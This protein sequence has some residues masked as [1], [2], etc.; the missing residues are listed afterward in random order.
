MTLRLVFP[1][2]LFHAVEFSLQWPQCIYI[3]TLVIVSPIDC[4]GFSVGW[5][6]ICPCFAYSGFALDHPNHTIQ[7]LHSQTTQLRTTS[8]ADRRGQKDGRRHRQVA[9]QRQTQLDAAARD[10]HPNQQPDSA[11]PPSNEKDR[12]G[13]LANETTV[14]SAVDVV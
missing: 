14:K 6:F 12:H 9:G 3:V 11:K 7:L 10:T 4:L 5:V 8:D 13:Q 2:C 1:G